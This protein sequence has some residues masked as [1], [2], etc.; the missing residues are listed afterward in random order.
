MCVCVCV[1][2]RA[3]IYIYTRTHARTHARTHTHTPTPIAADAKNI[4]GFSITYA[5]KLVSKACQQQVTHV[6]SK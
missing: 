6:S 3:R 4:S 1:C 2:A 5:V